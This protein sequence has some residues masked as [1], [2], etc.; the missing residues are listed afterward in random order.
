MKKTILLT[1]LALTIPSLS[2]AATQKNKY[3]YVY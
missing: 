1:I 2:L 3:N